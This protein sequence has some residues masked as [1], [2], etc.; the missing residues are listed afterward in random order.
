MKT[1]RLLFGTG[2]ALLSTGCGGNSS[3]SSGVSIFERSFHD[4]GETQ[5]NGMDLVVL[6]L[7]PAVGVDNHT[8]DIGSRGSDSVMLIPENSGEHLF[9]LQPANEASFRV[10]IR[11]T[12]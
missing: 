7:E 4:S 11:S 2:L 8:G 3:T 10:Q 1:L 5:A 12:A 9:S 6:T